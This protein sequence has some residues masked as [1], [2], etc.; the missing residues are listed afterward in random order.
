MSSQAQ[1]TKAKLT[2]WDYIKRKMFLTAKETANKTK[3]T[4][5]MEEETC[6]GSI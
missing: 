2:R 3:T 6:K 4:Y 5:R 1:K